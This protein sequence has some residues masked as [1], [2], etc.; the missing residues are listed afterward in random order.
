[1]NHPEASVL[2]AVQVDRA[3]RERIAG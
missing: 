2:M 3:H 1:L